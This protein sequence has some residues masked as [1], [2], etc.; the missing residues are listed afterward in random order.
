MAKKII[1]SDTGPIIALALL[2]LI[3]DMP[4]IIGEIIIPYTVYQECI[5]DLAKP[6]AQKIQYEFDRGKLKIQEISTPALLNEYT[7]LLDKGES[8]AIA[9]YQEI[10]AD[11]L[12]IDEIKG[13]KAAEKQQITI[14]G[15]LA[16]LVKAKEKSIIPLIKPMLEILLSH[17]YRLSKSLIQYILQRCGEAK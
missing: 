11:Y 9:L 7:L 4:D 15:T 16:I 3:K 1:V 17:N 2:N 13:R 10:H 8:E 6:A 5:C 12:L 14:I